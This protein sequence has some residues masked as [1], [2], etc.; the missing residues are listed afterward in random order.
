MKG[1][2][3]IAAVAR[4]GVIGKDGGLPWRIPEDTRHFMRTTKGHAVLMGRR[5]WEEVKK[6]L[7][8]RRNLVISRT[9][10]FLAPGAEV[11]PTL[12]AAIAAARETDPLPFV[13]GG[14]RL[15][16]EALP[17]ATLLYLT[18]I[19]RDAD[20]DTHF[21]PFDRSLFRELERRPAETETD[22][23]FVTLARIAE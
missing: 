5:T 3:L 21:P 17:L 19:D 23:S 11:F 16:A 8:G 2:A 9:P 18:E 20:G 10:G 14:T 22:V 13:I 7:P 15:Y 12:D 1:L 4:N 6:P